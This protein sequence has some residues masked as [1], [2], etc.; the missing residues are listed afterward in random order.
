[1]QL[2]KR[3]FYLVAFVVAL[4][5]LFLLGITTNNAT[6]TTISPTKVLSNDREYVLIVR[7]HKNNRALFFCYKKHGSIDPHAKLVVYSPSGRKYIGT[8]IF[9]NR[10]V[11]L[12]INPSTGNYRVILYANNGRISFPAIRISSNTPHSY[13]STQKADIITVKY[14][15]LIDVGKSDK[16]PFKVIVKTN[17]ATSRLE[18]IGKDKH[19]FKLIRNSRTY[20]I[21]EWEHTFYRGEVAPQKSYIKT[22]KII[23][24]NQQN[25]KGDQRFIRFKIKNSSKFIDILIERIK[26]DNNKRGGQCKAYL[27]RVFNKLARDYGM[28]CRMPKNQNNGVEWQQTRN[29]CFTVV[30]SYRAGNNP[31]RNKEEVI[32]LLKKARKGDI[33]QM[34]W[35][36]NNSHFRLTP[37]TLIFTKDVRENTI[38]NW[39]DSNLY[40][41]EIVRCGNTYPWGSLKTFDS[42]VNYLSNKFCTN[43]CGATLYRLKP[44]YLQ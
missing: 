9:K 43:R 41:R 16:T 38:L 31:Q 13:H 8:R 34:I 23:A 32:K 35:N 36:P 12:F 44:Q 7:K 28:S 22:M 33:L 2:R 20:K 26:K 6:A 14:P 37:H 10:A 29:S 42:L 11:Y 24:F 17:T 1:M 5:S 3:Y 39:C 15:H 21:W 19:T 27:F 4:I 25:L 30:A 40:G 18:I